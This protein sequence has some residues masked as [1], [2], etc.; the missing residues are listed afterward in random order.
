[1]PIK[2]QTAMIRKE[3][4]EPEK[5]CIWISCQL[6]WLRPDEVQNKASAKSRLERLQLFGHDQAEEVALALR[7]YICAVWFKGH[8][9]FGRS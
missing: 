1:M 5:H 3:I 9:E 8:F 7:L 2:R 4:N 6:H